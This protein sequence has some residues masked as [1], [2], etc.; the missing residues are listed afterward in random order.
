MTNIPEYLNVTS[1]AAF[2]RVVSALAEHGIAMRPGNG[3]MFSA[4]PW[5][6]CRG[7]NYPLHITPGDGKVLAYCFGGCNI[8][9]VLRMIGMTTGEL[10]DIPRTKA[11]DKRDV[12]A[13][14]RHSV[15]S[16]YH[17]APIAD[18]IERG[19]GAT[20]SVGAKNQP[21]GYRPSPHSDGC[22]A[23]LGMSVSALESAV[24]HDRHHHWID[25]T[26]IVRNC[27][28]PW[29][30]T[31]R[32]HRARYWVWA[33]EPCDPAT[34]SWLAA[35]RAEKYRH[36]V[37]IQAEKS[38]ADGYKKVPPNRKETNGLPA[39]T[40]TKVR[41]V[42]GRDGERAAA[43]EAGVTL[44]VI[45]G[46][47]RPGRPQVPDAAQR[48]ALLLRDSGATWQ[49]ITEA[50]GHSL[51]AIRRAV[52][53]LEYARSLGVAGDEVAE[54]RVCKEPALR[55]ARLCP[56]HQAGDVTRRA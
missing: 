3:K 11:P 28:R 32:G 40:P 1:S 54:C 21:P 26:C 49:Q 7:G 36:A 18:L 45:Q 42:L 34:C 50:T 33:G 41:N 5:H 8:E 14:L 9:D 6:T 46:G 15:L 48:Q 31:G 51:S 20:V 22:A 52:L 55:P 12:R 16:L 38:T 56:R 53:R 27:D 17:R 37:L 24:S 25:V 44:R 30:H 43:K 23:Q 4:C 35:A 19:Y 47:R 13:A 29:P 2:E 39:K 10:F